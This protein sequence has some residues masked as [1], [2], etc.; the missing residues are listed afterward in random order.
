M[1]GRRDVALARSGG[2]QHDR[3]LWSRGGALEVAV[4]FH[5]EGPI[6]PFLDL[7]HASLPARHGATSDHQLAT[8]EG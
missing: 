4:E 3:P 5:P 2:A 8:A 7:Q 6:E 1:V